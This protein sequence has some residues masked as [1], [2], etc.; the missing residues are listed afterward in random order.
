MRVREGNFTG[1]VRRT[2]ECK[3]VESKRKIK[4]RVKGGRNVYN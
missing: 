3:L 1:K 2:K 4:S